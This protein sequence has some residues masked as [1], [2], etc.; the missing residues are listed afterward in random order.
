MDMTKKGY[1]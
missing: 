1:R